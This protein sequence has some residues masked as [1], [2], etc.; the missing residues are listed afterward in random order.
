MRRVKLIMWESSEEGLRVYDA[1]RDETEIDDYLEL[2][3]R[4]KEE[5]DVKALLEFLGDEQTLE[6]LEKIDSNVK[7]DPKDPMRI[8]QYHWWGMSW[9]KFYPQIEFLDA[10]YVREW[11]KAYIEQEEDERLRELL[12]K[13]LRDA[14]ILNVRGYYLKLTETRVSVTV[15]TTLWWVRE[16]VVELK[17]AEELIDYLLTTFQ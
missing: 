9:V 16:A 6:E 11:L 5:N 12:L 7:I 2:L 13:Q 3:K 1:T 8:N 15:N 4:V 14:K 17:A 10:D